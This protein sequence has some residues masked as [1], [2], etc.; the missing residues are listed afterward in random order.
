VLKFALIGSAVAAAVAVAG[1]SGAALASPSSP[2]PVP[3][4]PDCDG[5]LFAISNHASGPYGPSGNPQAST[6]AG[7]FLHSDTGAEAAA[8]RTEYCG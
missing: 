3:G 4:T 8:Y 2:V 5:L 6:G 1:S 7:Y